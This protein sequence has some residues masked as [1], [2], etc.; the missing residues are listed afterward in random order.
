M[1][2]KRIETEAEHVEVFDTI[3][4]LVEMS[5]YDE[6]S[7]RRVLLAFASNLAHDLNQSQA[8]FLRDAAVVA[9][10]EWSTPNTEGRRASLRR[11][12]SN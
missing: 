4:Y 9:D 6:E 7:W 3:G 11:R 8:Q 12:R 2:K 1:G 10:E 5:P